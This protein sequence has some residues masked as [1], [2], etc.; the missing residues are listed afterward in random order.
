M[1]TFKTSIK[2]VAVLLFALG[3]GGGCETTDGGGQAGANNYYGS[4]FRDPWYYGNY[5][6]NGDVIVV[7]P[8]GNAPDNG[9]R[10]AHPIARPPGARPP[11][12]SIPSAPRP[13]PRP[14]MRR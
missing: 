2:L 13:A 8:P 4:G 1:N 9:L 14:A 11:R 7:P 12:P 6:D 10:P 3:I 5:H